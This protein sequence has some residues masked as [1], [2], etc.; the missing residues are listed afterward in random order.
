MKLRESEYIVDRLKA[1]VQHYKDVSDMYEREYNA[2][3]E[4]CKFGAAVSGMIGIC[5]GVLIGTLFA[6]L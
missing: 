3:R 2:L 1:E 6:W 4:E 5:I